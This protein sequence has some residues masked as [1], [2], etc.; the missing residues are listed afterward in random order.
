MYKKIVVASDLKVLDVND[1]CPYCSRKRS[2]L[3]AMGMKHCCEEGRR[4]KSSQGSQQRQT[5]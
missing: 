4:W 3:Q 1:R 5:N 2:T